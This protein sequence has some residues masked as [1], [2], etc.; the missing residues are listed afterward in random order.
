MPPDLSTLIC[1]LVTFLPSVSLFYPLLDLLSIVILTEFHALNSQQGE[2]TDARWMQGS[3]ESILVTVCFHYYWLPFL[4]GKPCWAKLTISLEVLDTR[5]GAMD[6]ALLIFPSQVSGFG[7]LTQVPS[8]LIYVLLIPELPWLPQFCSSPPHSQQ[9]L[10]FRVDLRL[11]LLKM[12]A[13]I[14]ANSRNSHSPTSIPS[15]SRKTKLAPL[16]QQLCPASNQSEL[17]KDHSA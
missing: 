7:Y 4:W 10:A 8:L 16:N 15:R 11:S 2:E 1:M 3:R 13:E 12:P 9:S 6:M 5:Q 17:C 14:M